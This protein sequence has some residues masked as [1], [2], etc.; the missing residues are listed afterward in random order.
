MLRSVLSKGSRHISS[1]SG[2]TPSPQAE[3]EKVDALAPF[4]VYQGLT[5]G[6]ARVSRED[7]DYESHFR[8]AG[9]LLTKLKK[10]Y[11]N[12]IAMATTYVIPVY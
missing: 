8:S 1:C 12:A 6:I 11:W 3:L 2:G 5:I 10:L 7:C 4:E 9:A